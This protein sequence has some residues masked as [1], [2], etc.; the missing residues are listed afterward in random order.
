MQYARTKGLAV[1]VADVSELKLEIAK[2]AGA[3]FVARSGESGRAIQKEF[4]GVDAA[5]VFTDS[6]EAMQQA[7][8]SVKRTGAIVLVGLTTRDLTISVTETVLKGLRL[9]GSFLG[10]RDDLEAV[11]RLAREQDIRPA[12]ETFALEQAPEVLTRLAAGEIR[13]RAVIGF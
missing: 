10:T 6:T 4:G 1:A 3:M 2:A 7:I 13:G 11:F 12:T 9:T 8:K 5:I